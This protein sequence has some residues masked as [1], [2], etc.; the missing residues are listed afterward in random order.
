MG[1]SW[2]EALQDETHLSLR[3]WRR[4]G[5]PV[6]TAL[7]FERVGERLY[8]RTMQPSGKVRRIRN[9][10]DVMIAP[11][12]AD[13]TPTGPFQRAQARIL[14]E[15]AAETAMV[16]AAL[17]ARYGEER[18]AMTQLMAERGIPL[19]YIEVWRES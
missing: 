4:D 6:D 17:Q 7:W 5:R 11:C 14:P 13:G 1:A 12:L 15:G 18:T 3:S 8:M 9:R 2:L 10:S 19:C 16:E